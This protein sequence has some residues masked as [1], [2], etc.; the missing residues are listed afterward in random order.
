MKSVV[1][2]LTICLSL[3]LTSFSAINSPSG[4]LCPMMESENAEMYPM[5]HT[6]GGEKA[7]P[8][9]VASAQGLPPAAEVKDMEKAIA[10]A[11]GGLQVVIAQAG[12]E[13]VPVGVRVP[14]LLPVQH[15]EFEGKKMC[16]N[17]GKEKN[18]DCHR[19]CYNGTPGKDNMCKN[20]CWED[21]CGC[22]TACNS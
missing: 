18:C 17:Y 4:D 2:A 5:T 6:E 7:C 14:S 15:G 3:F 16:Y 22:R 12:N 21:K 19:M 20:Y 11:M 1:L 13:G 9:H 10:E 8:M